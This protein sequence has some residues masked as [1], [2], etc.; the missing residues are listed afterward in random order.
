MVAR[1]IISIN[2]AGTRDAKEIAKLAVAQLG[3]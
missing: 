2:A 1:K 3:P